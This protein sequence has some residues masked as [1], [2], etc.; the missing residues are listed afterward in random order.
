[1]IDLFL[2]NALTIVTEFIGISLASATLGCRRS[3]RH[4]R[5]IA[6]FAAVSTGS[7]RRF[8]RLCLVLVAGS[9]PAHPDVSIVHPPIGQMTHDFFVPGLPGGSAAF[10]RNAADHRDRRHHR[11]ALAA[12]LPAVLHHRQA[13]HAA[14]HALRERDLVIGIA[15]VIIGAA[16][17]MGFLTPCSPG[18]P[19]R[20]LHRRRWHRRASAAYASDA[21]GVLFAIALLDA[22]IIGAAAVGLATAYATA[23]SSTSTTPCTGLSRRPRGSTPATR[24]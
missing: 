22:S 9:L 17:M 8:E 18:P 21:A 5:G 11:R 4:P 2:L 15:L 7:F 13:H 20:A 3:R 16:A 10:H 23:T 12:L 1:M 6:H 19:V 24:A 14:L